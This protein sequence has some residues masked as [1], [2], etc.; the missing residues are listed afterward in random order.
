M[1]NQKIKNTAS[2]RRRRNDIILIV[3]ILAAVAVVAVI[4]LLTRKEGAY[5]AIVKDG[6]EIARYSLAEEREIPIADGEIVTNL[7]VIKGGKAHIREA[8]CPDQICVE[9]RAVSKAGETIVCLPQKLV[10]RIVA[11]QGDGPDMVA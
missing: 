6:Q 10:I 1:S 9:H 8:I 4:F 5:A 3:G 7:L 11:E 2:L